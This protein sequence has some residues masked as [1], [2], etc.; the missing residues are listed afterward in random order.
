[1]KLYLY[2]IYLEDLK[3]FHLAFAIVAASKKEARQMALDHIATNR[4]WKKS[5]IKHEHC[6]ATKIWGRGWFEST[7]VCELV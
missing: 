4:T 6:K 7:L 2:E 1:M 3:S 5:K